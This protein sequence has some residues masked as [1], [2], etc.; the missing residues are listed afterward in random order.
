MKIS[1][2]L[3][4]RNEEQNIARALESVRWADELIVVDACSTDCTA[5]IA[6]AHGAIVLVRPWPGFAEQRNWALQQTSGDWILPLDAD[7]VVDPELGDEIRRVVESSGDINGYWIARRNIVFGRWL[8]RGGMWPDYKLRLFRRG[9]GQFQNRPVHEGLDVRGK[10]ERLKHSF[11]HYTYPTIE[12]YIDTMNRYSSLG[13]VARGPRAFSFINIAVRPTIRFAYNYLFRLGF[14]DGREGFLF[15]LYH[16]AYVSWTYA[17]AWE[18]VVNK[19]P[20]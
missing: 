1:V 19:K 5:E 13:A 20:E 8:R 7:E 6:R 16:S 18:M 12:G 11:A 9:T 10:T 15:H 14:L 4:T 17:K 2:V 3:I